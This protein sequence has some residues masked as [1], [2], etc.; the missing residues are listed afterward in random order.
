MYILYLRFLV[1]IYGMANFLVVLIVEGL[2][3]TVIRV[4]IFEWFS[5][6]K[7]RFRLAFLDCTDETV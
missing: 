5:L 6:F 2:R 7:K 1:R 4:P 3:L